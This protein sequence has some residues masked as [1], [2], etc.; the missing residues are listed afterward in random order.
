MEQTHR[1]H[2]I[3]ILRN[4][5]H[6]SMILPS[7]EFILLE[8]EIG[9]VEG[10]RSLTSPRISF[11]ANLVHH[12]NGYLHASKMKEIAR[13][14]H[15]GGIQIESRILKRKRIIFF[16]SIILGHCDDESFNVVPKKAK[17]LN[18]RA[19]GC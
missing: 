17:F 6:R 4:S 16:K 15:E 14:N 3:Y 5:F 10:K 13:L 12:S 9:V 11:G 8:R 2:A 1:S 18:T 19:P 7:L